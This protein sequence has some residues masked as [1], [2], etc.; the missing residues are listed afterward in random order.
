MLAM[1]AICW[2]FLYRLLSVFSSPYGADIGFSTP[3]LNCFNIPCHASAYLLA[4]N[5]SLAS[6]DSYARPLSSNVLPSSDCIAL[7]L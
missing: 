1:L 5:L 2:L 6:V 4:D 7:F 3:P